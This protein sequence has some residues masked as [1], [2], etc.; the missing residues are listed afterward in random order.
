MDGEDRER[1]MVI[2]LLVLSA[3]TGLI[4]VIS[5]LGLGKVFTANMT[6]NIVF[7]GFAPGS[8]MRETGSARTIALLGVESNFRF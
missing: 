1:P 4:D 7:P 3:T 8:F 2:L 5:V 6:G